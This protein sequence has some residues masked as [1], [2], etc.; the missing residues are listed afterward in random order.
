MVPDLAA[1]RQNYK[2][3]G[4]N[5]SDLCNDP[6]EQFRRWFEDACEAGIHEPN[7]MALATVG[8]NGQPSVRIVLL[9]VID[10]QGLAFFTNLNSR[11]G[12]ELKGNPK[13]ALNFWWGPLMRQVGIEGTVERVDDT[14]ADT[15]FASRPVGSR[16]CAWASEQS[17]VIEN[18]ATLEAAEREYRERYPGD[19]VPRPGS[20][21]G[22]RLVPS[23]VEFWQGRQNRLHDRLRYSRAEGSCWQIERL[24]P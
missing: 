1:M 16:I 10:Q 17:G 9:K 13:A 7:S 15:Y 5:E 20:W 11:K 3:N 12:Q 24:A 4:L 18:R 21:G 6:I 22:V 23:R 14:E 2:A 19:D 8:S